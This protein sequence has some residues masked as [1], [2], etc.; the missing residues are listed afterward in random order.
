MIDGCGFK[1]IK[2]EFKDYLWIYK[3]FPNFFKF[4]F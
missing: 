3:I 1:V 2:K 4:F